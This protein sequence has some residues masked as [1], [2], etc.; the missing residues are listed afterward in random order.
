MDNQF[1]VYYLQDINNLIPLSEVE[2]LDADSGNVIEI[3]QKSYLV[4]GII[5]IYCYKYTVLEWIFYEGSTLL[6]FM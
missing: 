3:I 4:S 1:I 6:P 2:T 5:R